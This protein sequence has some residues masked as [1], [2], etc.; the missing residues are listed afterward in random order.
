[1]NELLIGLLS[2]LV[3]TNPPAAVSNL[4]QK[5]T[6]LTLAVVDPK[7]PVEQTYQRLMDADD[8]AQAEVDDWIQQRQKEGRTETDVEK[9]AFQTRIKRRFAPVKQG[10]EGF[11][12]AHPGHARA[13]LA[14]GS[15]LNDIGEEDAAEAQWE[16]ACELDPK[17]PAAWNNLAT[18]YGHNG[19]VRKA[20]EYYAKAIGIEPTE[21]LYYQNFATT[22]FLFR[23]DAM[24]FYQITE[25]EVFEKAM[26]LYRK[27]LSL[28][29][30]NFNLAA[31]V[32]QTYYGIK[33]PKSGDAA[34]SR[35]A[36]LKL[37]DEALSA[38][39]VA[40]KLARNDLERES[41]YLHFTRWQINSGRFGDARKSLSVVTNELLSASKKTLAKKLALRE[42]APQETNAAPEAVRGPIRAR[43]EEAPVEPLPRGKSP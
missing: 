2:A 19:D 29:P 28:D 15:F 5:R 30:E 26:T 25:Q 34:A 6:G 20:F 40:L 12:E 7:D 13:R 8:A 43:E 18:H 23:K 17:N 16:K 24:E 33:S 36:E 10:Y 9:A 21:P 4:V 41:V 14:Y 32:A 11:L 39:Q 3:A 37:A 1:M 35:R 22:V 38:W 31:E 27:A 42:A